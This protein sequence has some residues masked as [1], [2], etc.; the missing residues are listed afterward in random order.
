MHSRQFLSTKKHWLPGL[1]APPGAWMHGKYVVLW[2]RP[3]HDLECVVG[4]LEGEAPR[5]C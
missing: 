5:I 1:T 2:M 4:G 3:E